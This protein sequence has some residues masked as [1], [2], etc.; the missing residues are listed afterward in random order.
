VRCATATPTGARV[1]SLL[2]Q[3]IGRKMN[4]KREKILEKVV[5]LF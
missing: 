4:E 1:A 3:Q 5:C 2:K